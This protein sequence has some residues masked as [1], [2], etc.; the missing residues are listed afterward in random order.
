MH[1][2][3]I[4]TVMN[5]TSTLYISHGLYVTVDLINCVFMYCMSVKLP[6][7]YTTEP[8]KFSLKFNACVSKFGQ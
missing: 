6:C 5:H 2:C 8:L 7:K 3:T 4:C 1:S